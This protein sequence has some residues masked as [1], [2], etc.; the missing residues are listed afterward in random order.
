MFNNCEIEVEIY[1]SAVLEVFMM[2]DD[3]LEANLE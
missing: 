2:S 3:E 1:D